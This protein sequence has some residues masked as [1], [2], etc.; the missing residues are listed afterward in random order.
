[1]SD[2]FISI[3]IPT[4]NSEHYIENSVGTVIEIVKNEYE[5]F[6]VILVNDS[7]SDNTNEKITELTELYSQIKLITTKENS[8][9]TI[10]TILGV[11]AASGNYIVTIDDDLEYNFREFKNMIEYLTIN[12]FLLVY[13]IDEDYEI[14]NRKT[15]PEVYKNIA[16][17]LLFPNKINYRV[18]GFRVI[19]KSPHINISEVDLIGTFWKIPNK[20][21]SNYNVKRN[22]RLYRKYSA[23]ALF[24]HQLFF[25][26]SIT[27][28]L[29]ILFIITSICFNSVLSISFSILF[30]L[31][32]L[33]TLMKITTIKKQKYLLYDKNCSNR[34]GPGGK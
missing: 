3:V 8:G 32:Y 21:I 9:Q 11:K 14:K 34:F 30:I 16:G 17:I 24:K 4:Y 6:E 29:F 31:L 5:N 22:K 12:N 19:K 23:A 28:N 7:S 27:K 25:I 13:G 33:I 2:T 18:S 10:A 20:L 1:M 15:L 26:H